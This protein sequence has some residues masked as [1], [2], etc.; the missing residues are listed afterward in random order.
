MSA[1]DIIALA[2]AGL[3]LAVS[4]VVAFRQEIL[5]RRAQLLAVTQE[6]MTEFRSA[7][8]KDRL[9]YVQ[10]TL[11]GD[12]PARD[13]HGPVLSDQSW[14]K[15]R[16]VMSYFNAVGLLVFHGTVS[17]EVVASVMGGSLMSAWKELAPYVYAQRSRRG[18]D[19]NYYG[20]FEHVAALV[21]EIGP[22]RLDERLRLRKLPPERAELID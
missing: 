21:A 18:G 16:P 11:A 1:S 8:F 10:R 3:A 15:A 2:S 20:Y 13:E 22:A 7:D 5:T 19:P 6:V 14:L 4:V 9:T 12:S 17:A